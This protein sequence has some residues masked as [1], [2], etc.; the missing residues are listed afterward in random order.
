MV[1]SLRGE[2]Y[3]LTSM[4]FPEAFRKSR[5]S[6]HADCKNGDSE[7]GDGA[8]AGQAHRAAL[9]RGAAWGLDRGRAAGLQA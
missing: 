2:A 8:L 6:V 3:Q 9:S 5:D 4:S 7:S 1:F